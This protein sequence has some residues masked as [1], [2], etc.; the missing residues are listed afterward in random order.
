MARIVLLRYFFFAGGRELQSNLDG[1]LLNRL[2]TAFAACLHLFRA[3]DSYVAG[4]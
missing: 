3:Q 2:V 1:Q 4:R